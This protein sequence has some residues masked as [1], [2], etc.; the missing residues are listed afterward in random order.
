M[1]L[2]EE[3]QEPLSAIIADIA[4]LAYER[5]VMHDEDFAEVLCSA[6]EGTDLD[7]IWKSL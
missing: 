2:P 4:W 3:D 6:F 7:S 1:E 5:V